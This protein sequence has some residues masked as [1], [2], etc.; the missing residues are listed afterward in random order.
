MKKI[1]A[2]SWLIT[3]ATIITATTSCNISIILIVLIMSVRRLAASENSILSEVAR[4]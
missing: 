2:W 1:N 4:D 3:I